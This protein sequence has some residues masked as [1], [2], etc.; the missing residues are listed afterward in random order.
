MSTTVA[1]ASA[2]MQYLPA[3][4]AED[5]FLGQFL[6]AFE[7]LLLGR[8][9][10]IPIPDTS[11]ADPSKQDSAN[12]L[13]GVANRGLEQI[14]AS[15]PC[16]FDPTQVREEFLPWL[17]EWS[18]FTLRADI[19]QPRQREFL[20][21][22]ISLY[23]RRGTKKNLQELLGIFTHGRPTIREAHGEFRVGVQ[24]TVG[25]DTWVGEAPVHF[26]QVIVSWAHGSLERLERDIA[27]THSLIELEKPAHTAYELQS[28]FPTL[29][30][31]KYSTVGVDTLLGTP[32]PASGV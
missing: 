2:L 21:K 23:S 7:K 31:G 3:I 17:A 16:L 8:D 24:S 4:Y 11:E 10:G 18:M 25:E 22:V 30:I 26:F 6:Q 32:D 5:P 1:A 9:D 13:C 15:L 12:D 27:I 14:I 28:V 19:D 29:V 20:A